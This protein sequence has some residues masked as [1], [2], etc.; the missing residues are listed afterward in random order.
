M[1]GTRRHFMQAS[2]GLLALLPSAG[3]AAKP[4]MDKKPAEWSP[5]DI[6]IILNR[7]GWTRQ[8]SPEFVP[9]AI[10]PADGKAGRRSTA[11]GGL[12][13]KRILPDFKVLVR[14]ESGLPVRLARKTSPA[15]NDASHYMLSMSRVPMAFMAALSTGGRAGQGAA[16]GA[17]PAE[18]A[19]RVVPFSSIQRDGKEPLPADQAYWSESDFESRIM[20]SFSKGRQPIELTEREVT[21]VSRIGDLI[22]RAP[23]FL[24]EMMYHGK[25][26]L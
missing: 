3:L 16:N 7:S 17:D 25:L 14:W 2:S 15:S 1:V 19:A 20:I 8:A 6:D 23:F 26:E 5:S 12:R 9:E 10:E 24:K 11:A 4:W 18:M 22:V 13:D 21:F